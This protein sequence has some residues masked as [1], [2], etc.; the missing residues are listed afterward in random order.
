LLAAHLQAA[1][2]QTWQSHVVLV[3]DSTVTDESGWGLGFSACLAD[4]IKCTNLSLGGR[5][6]SSFSKEGHWQKALELRPDWILIQFGHNDEPGHAEKSNP[7]RGGYRDNIMRYI[8]EAREA[9]I[10]PVLVT[11]IS[12]RQWGKAAADKNCI[13]SSLQEYATVVKDVAAE[14][15]VPLIDLHGRSMEVYESLGPKACEMITTRK[16]NGQWDG[17]HMNRA[18]A[19]M[20]GSMVAM[21]CRSYIPAMRPFFPTSK[22][23]ELQKT[24]P[25][26]SMSD[27]DNKPLRNWNGKPTPQGKRQITVAR[28]GSGDFRTL[29]EAIAAAPNNNSD[30]TIIRLKD[31]VYIGQVI[32]PR[33]K[34]NIVLLGE[35]P[36]ETIVSY[37]LS[38]HDPIPPDVSREFAGYGVVVLADGFR[39]TNLTIRQNSGDHGQAIALRIDGDRAVLTNCNLLGWQDTVRLENGR[40]YLY[41]CHIEGRV[42]YIYG[43]ATAY[44]ENCTVHTK[45]DGYITAASTPHEKPWG[46]VFQNCRL[47]GTGEGVVFLGRPWRPY[48]SVTYLNCEMDHS[49]RPVGWDNWR[50]PANEATA[51]YNEFNSRGPGAAPSARAAWSS[52]LSKAEAAEI[53]VSKV[54]AGPD[55]WDPAQVSVDLTD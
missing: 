5:S 52:Q 29:Q 14:L 23:A 33:S 31:G 46:Y 19:N 7:P 37:A 55:G 9:S 34:P 35:D 49:I 30:Q 44:F 21:D 22:L 40:Q 27:A 8:K 16:E 25:A 24:Q 2:P 3:G 54:L 50:N 32:I 43:S 48:A 28:D 1:E 18:G 26:P 11:P 6:S 38:V 42:D 41:D 13:V 47:T 39:A 10:Q 17:T 51:R 15:D 12:R 36:K 45:N 53:T 20:F 4:N